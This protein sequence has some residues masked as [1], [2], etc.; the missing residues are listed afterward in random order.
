LQLPDEL[1]N[2][3][4]LSNNRIDLITPT[5]KIQFKSHF[6][7]HNR[8]P[9]D[10]LEMG[11]G[12]KEKGTSKENLLVQRKNFALLLIIVIL[13]FGIKDYIINS[14]ISIDEDHKD[15]VNVLSE[16]NML[17]QRITK[18][19]LLI[20]NDLDQ[21][22]I[23]RSRLDSLEKL[24][25]RWRKNHE[26]LRV[27]NVKHTEDD[28]IAEEVSMLI[29]K[30]DTL[31][32]IISRSGFEILEYRLVDRKRFDR[33]VK[34]IDREELPYHALV[35]RSLQLYRSQI[36]NEFKFLKN[37]QFG[38]S[39]IAILTLV[40]GFIFLIIPL[41]KVLV[42]EINKRKQVEKSLTNAVQK[43]LIS[44]ITLRKN[45]RELEE[46][47]EAIDR[48][49]LVSITDTE[50]QIIKAN[51]LFCE[52]VGYTEQ[53]LI[54][55]SHRIISSQS[56]SQEFWQDFWNTIKS[57][58]SWKGEVKN[59][60]KDG[61]VIWMETVINPIMGD[62]GNIRHFLAIR[63]DITNRKLAEQL[64]ENLNSK[65]RAILNT[66]FPVGIISTDIQGQIVFFSK[67]AET[68]L[69]YAKEEL[70]GKT[71]VTFHDSNEV[72]DR[73]SELSKQF[74]R[75][76][77]GF[78]AFIT[79]PNRDGYESRKWTYI[80]KNGTR[81]P[82][83]LVV[84]PIK[85]ANDQI[86]GYVGIAT[87]INDRIDAEKAMQ[88][89]KE[90]AEEAN[91]A[92]SQFLANMSHEIRTPLNSILGFS[93]LLLESAENPKQ[94]SQ[95]GIIYSNGKTLL[96]LINDLLNIAK[97]EAGKLELEPEVT[98]IFNTANEVAKMFYTE[99]N[100]RNVHLT[101]EK[102]KNFPELVLIDEIRLRQVLIN[103]VGNAVK[104]T[105]DGFILLTL[106]STPL[107]DK[108]DFEDVVIRI[109]DSGLG[110]D[111][112][113]HQKI[114]EAF[115]QVQDTTTSQYGG[116]GLGLTISNKIIRLMGGNIQ[117]TSELGKGSTFIIS[118]PGLQKIELK[119]IKAENQAVSEKISSSESKSDFSILIVDDVQS[120]I[121]LLI[122][123][124][125]NYPYRIFIA[126]GGEEAVALAKQYQP[127]LILMDL[128]M[129][130]VDGWQAARRIRGMEGLKRTLIVACTANV[131]N[132]ADEEKIFNGIIFK[133]V[134]KNP[135]LEELKKYEALAGSSVITDEKSNT[136]KAEE[137]I[138]SAVLENLRSQ[139]GS[140]IKS[141]CN[142]FEVNELEKLISELEAY[143]I[144]YQDKHLSELVNSAKDNFSRFDL[145][146]ISDALRKLIS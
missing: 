47:N 32:K 108:R 101:V 100:K 50:G 91:H 52:T 136:V 18:L 34:I 36:E 7:I 135:F 85:E 66:D 37:L 121:D 130:V 77:S 4:R 19:A 128:K 20:Q 86:S 10:S 104:F 80:R 71:P 64:A 2:F 118:I 65:L 115:Y 119:K 60:T 116:T 74:N 124:L 21:D 88:F 25:P 43:Y 48:S 134:R 44:E 144:E 137:V 5:K 14:L 35:D 120:N 13:T 31:V 81:I 28:Y 143:S 99:I 114:F 105:H 140:R 39:I 92:K 51:A 17:S 57:G 61:R 102:S 112:S 89:A 72:I 107:N 30:M 63:I 22:T 9:E 1:L 113:Q 46:I 75:T 95:L 24:L 49:G 23:A 12:E 40:I 131:T 84:S 33:A 26:W 82:V 3:R 139:F 55:K 11:N 38:L 97:I 142:N 96:A 90:K 110:I 56:H 29:S 133:P 41:F 78:E 27:N 45:Q 58:K 69:G 93:E 59:R 15:I 6:I 127:D 76:I 122:S 103:I 83:Q 111:Q 94:K 141:A 68:L 16:Q 106:E 125:E 109:Q 132:L 79:I 98:D 62:G 53:E 54:G 145:D 146:G 70:I 117:V 129:P 67:G 87:D 138:D 123:Y 73:C 8:M 42:N 126:H